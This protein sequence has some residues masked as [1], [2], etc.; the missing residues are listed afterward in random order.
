MINYPL[1]VVG[2]LGM[3]LAFWL[4]GGAL[5][6]MR[7]SVTPCWLVKFLQRRITKYDKGLVVLRREFAEWRYY[8][9]RGEVYLTRRINTEQA[10]LDFCKSLLRFLEA[11]GF[12]INA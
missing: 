8:E 6:D 1:I 11:V 12:S 10:K 7:S 2:L 4:I 3:V 5:S 9:W